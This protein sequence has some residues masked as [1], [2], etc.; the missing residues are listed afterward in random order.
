MPAWPGA[1]HLPTISIEPARAALVDLSTQPAHGRF[2][3]VEQHA[4]LHD[5][6][7]IHEPAAAT[8]QNGDIP[9]PVGIR[10]KLFYV[11]ECLH[12]SCLTIIAPGPVH[13]GPCCPLNPGNG[14]TFPPPSATDPCSF[15]TWR[16]IRRQN[17]WAQDLGPV[18]RPRPPG[19]LGPK[20]PDQK[21][22]VPRPFLLPRDGAPWPT[23]AIRVQ[24]PRGA[25][26]CP[27]PAPEPL[28]EAAKPRPR[29]GPNMQRWAVADQI[30][31]STRGDLPPSPAK[32][33]VR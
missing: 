18:P 5:M 31:G 25:A 9:S 21:I 7:Q 15:F 10:P 16:P 26:P 12:G 33:L 1:A 6:V 27:G 28:K 17:P 14:V 2:G 24:I 19:P 13:A 32:A 3:R 8:V 29:R 30:V 4:V 20:P 22:P 23:Q 11:L